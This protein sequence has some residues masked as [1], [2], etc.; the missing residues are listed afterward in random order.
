MR[1]VR[2]ESHRGIKARSG[3]TQLCDDA[4]LRRHGRRAADAS[5][6]VH[7]DAGQA[8]AGGSLCNADAYRSQNPTALCT[9]CHLAVEKGA[10]TLNF[11]I[12]IILQGQCDYV[13]SRKIKIAGSHE[14]LQA[15]RIRHVDGRDDTLLIGSGYPPPT[16]LR[17]VN[18]DSVLCGNGDSKNQ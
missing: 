7:T 10:V 11:D 2:V 16:T 13:L 8:H 9:L 18:P 5:A 14:L 17:G 3:E 15:I 12:E 4:P 1:E 6:C